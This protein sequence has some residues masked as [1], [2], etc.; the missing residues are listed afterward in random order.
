MYAYMK[1]T[2]L[3]SV[4]DIPISGPETAKETLDEYQLCFLPESDSQLLPAQFACV[5]QLPNE[6]VQKLQVRMR[7]LYHLAYPDTSTRNNIFLNERFI[8]ALNNR[9]VQNHVCRRKPVTYAAALAAAIEE[10]SFV[11]MDLATH[12]PGGVQAPVLGDTSF[13]T[14]MKA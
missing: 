3:E 11:I 12:A 10:T 4:M 9:E 2:A 5:V 8:S 14:A 7:V 6:L 1:G 13:I